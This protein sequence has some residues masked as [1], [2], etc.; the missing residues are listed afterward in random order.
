M[1][2]SQRT[3]R[4]LC[5]LGCVYSAT[6]T[7]AAVFHIRCRDGGADAIVQRGV[8]SGRSSVCDVDRA[9]DG[10]CTFAISQA[11]LPCY[12]GLCPPDVECGNDPLPPCPQSYTLG[13]YAVD[14]TGSGTTATFYVDRLSGSPPSLLGAGERAYAGQKGS[15]CAQRSASSTPVWAA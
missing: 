14:I 10:V 9:C 7:V 4:T 11:C 8:L 6:P 2:S 13:A 3:W 5:I 12:L 1:R 15:R